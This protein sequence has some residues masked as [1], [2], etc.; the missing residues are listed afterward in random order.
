MGRGMGGRWPQKTSQSAGMPG[1]ACL[2]QSSKSGPCSLIQSCLASS[3]PTPTWPKSGHP[4]HCTS[5]A[6]AAVSHALWLPEPRPVPAT[7][8][9]KGELPCCTLCALVRLTPRSWFLCPPPQ[10]L[11]SLLDLE[12]LPCSCIAPLDALLPSLLLAASRHSATLTHRSDPHGVV[13]HAHA[14]LH[15]DPGVPAP[16]TP[17]PSE[18]DTDGDSDD[19]V[20]D[21]EGA[22]GTQT[23]GAAAHGVCSGAASAHVTEAAA[24]VLEQHQGQ[25]QQQQQPVLLP[26]EGA[27]AGSSCSCD[28][29]EAAMQRLLLEIGE[30]PHRRGLQGSARRYVE[31][32]LASTSGYQQQLPHGVTEPVLVEEEEEGSGRGA[33]PA[34]T[35]AGGCPCCSAA[36]G[37][38]SGHG[39]PC[40]ALGRQQVGTEA[41]GKWSSWGRAGSGSG[42]GHRSCAE[43]GGQVVER[44]TEGGLV[45]V[46]LP[47][48]S[49]CEHHMLP[50]YGTLMVAYR[51]GR[52]G[53][54]EVQGLQQQGDDVGQQE[55][56]CVLDVREVEA[57]VS[58]FTQRLQVQ[59]RITHQVADAVGQLVG[60]RG[61]RRGAESVEGGREGDELGC[62]R[63][64]GAAGAGAGDV[65]VVCDAAHM[66]MV[67]RGVENH[68][69]STTSFAVRGAF[70]ERAELRREVLRLFRQSA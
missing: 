57:V 45:T 42:R 69:G 48:A 58:V 32:L 19:L 37:G 56:G 52:E 27:E 3:H 70:A 15:A 65:M 34:V 66:C 8:R 50:F 1:R 38:R 68:S 33:G 62:Q 21:G 43:G 5:T 49:Q 18:K 41:E 16:G 60:R 22:E 11:L 4:R 51:L 25:G 30:D 44:R 24:A 10:E 14:H 2:S 46:R 13:S 39:R 6:A 63:G 26:A 29:M 61:D 7:P 31:S 36:R 47:F 53:V 35:P 67:A 9:I 23:G 55:A 28:S 17:D 20:M 12:D 64:A 40:S 59:E 54:Q